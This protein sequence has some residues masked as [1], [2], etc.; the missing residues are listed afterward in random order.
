MPSRISALLL[1]AAACSA[2]GTSVRGSAGDGDVA[3][4]LHSIDDA[5]TARGRT[6]AQMP[7][8]GQD[9]KMPPRATWPVYVSAKENLAAVKARLAKELAPAELAKL[10]LRVLP[11]DRSQLTDQG[12][13][14][15]PG[16][17]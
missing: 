17:Y 12:L 13:L 11:E 1:A 16:P 4:V 14:Y 8:A 2:A 15:L 3:A 6:Q 7:Q 5:W 9:P 10:D